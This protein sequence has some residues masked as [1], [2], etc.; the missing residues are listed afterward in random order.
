MN[1]SGNSDQHSHWSFLQ[2]C[3]KC[4]R[5]VVSVAVAQ[6][7]LMG[8]EV[9]GLPSWVLGDCKMELFRTALGPGGGNDLFI[10]IFIARSFSLT[11][12]K[13][14]KPAHKSW[15]I[16]CSP[17]LGSFWIHIKAN[18]LNIEWYSYTEPFDIAK[19]ID[20]TTEQNLCCTVGQYLNVGGHLHPF[21]SVIWVFLGWWEKLCLNTNSKVQIV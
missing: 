4:C 3:W 1:A 20:Q 13:N 16:R 11:L 10:Y 8:R 14:C 2:S 9:S 17:H 15:I 7:S 18:C 6:F 21:L 19:C 12:L 5:T